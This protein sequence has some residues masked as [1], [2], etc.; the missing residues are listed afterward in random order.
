MEDRVE[1]EDAPAY[2]MALE[3]W[4]RLF[5][6]RGSNPRTMWGR[7]PLPSLCLGILG[8]G[9]FVAILLTHRSH[10]SHLSV[11]G[12]LLAFGGFSLFGSLAM[13][14]RTDY[15]ES[16]GEPDPYAPLGH[17]PTK[18]SWWGRSELRNAPIYRGMAWLFTALGLALLLASG[19]TEVVA[20]LM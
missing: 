4:G 19:V 3:R 20:L 7:V 16:Y 12:W 6:R 2:R 13:W 10:G 1:G 11:A 14:G 18:P 9:I 5:D 17:Q 8:L 15:A